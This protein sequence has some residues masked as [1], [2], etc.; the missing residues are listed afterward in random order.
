[1]QKFGSRN[2]EIDPEFTRISEQSGSLSE[3]RQRSRC[4]YE[5]ILV[6][7]ILCPPIVPGNYVEMSSQERTYGSQVS[8][9]C[10]G[11]QRIVGAESITCL[12]NETWSDMPPNCEGRRRIANQTARESDVFAN[13]SELHGVVQAESI[14]S[15]SSEIR[16]FF[17]SRKKDRVR[18][19]STDCGI[20]DRSR[21]IM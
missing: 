9:S 3:I 14:F 1:M 13:R 16:L 4:R 18:V 11:G 5:F 8:F 20:N 19:Y 6:P 10:P 17:P 15:N 21:G 2:L 7:G 12:R